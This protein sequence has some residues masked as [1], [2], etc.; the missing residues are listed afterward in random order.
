MMKKLTVDD[1]CPRDPVIAKV[2]IVQTPMQQVH[3]L[4]QYVVFYWLE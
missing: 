2:I 3:I 4:A 1:F